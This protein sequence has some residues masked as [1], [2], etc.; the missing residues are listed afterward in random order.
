MSRAR[1]QEILAWALGERATVVT[2]DADFHTILA[3]RR[4]P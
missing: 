3:P 4:L 1:D 2:L